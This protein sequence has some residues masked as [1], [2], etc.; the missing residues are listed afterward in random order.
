MNPPA[1]FTHTALALGIMALVAAA[2]AFGA[3]VP[4]QIAAFAGAGCGSSYY[5]GREL[6]QS[7]RQ[8]NPDTARIGASF[9]FEGVV[10]SLVCHLVAVATLFV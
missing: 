2:Y 1:M 4:V 9:F 10:P 6:A 8:S 5:L 7:F 3:G